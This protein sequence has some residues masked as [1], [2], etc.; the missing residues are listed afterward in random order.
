[1]IGE[2]IGAIC[3]MGEEF[4]TGHYVTYFKESGEWHRQD[5]MAHTLQKR[6][7]DQTFDDI[8]VL[9]YVTRIN[10]KY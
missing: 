10:S 9:N 6:P 7:I 8:Q 2:L 3:H 4:N 5:T 1:M